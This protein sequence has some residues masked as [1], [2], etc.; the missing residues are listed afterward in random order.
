MIELKAGQL[1]RLK[2]PMNPTL[3]G[4]IVMIEKK[5]NGPFG[6]LY[7]FHLFKQKKYHD[8]NRTYSTEVENFSAFSTAME[9]FE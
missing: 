6:P 7:E 3:H 9:E 2:V 5:I 1:A 8:A 4:E